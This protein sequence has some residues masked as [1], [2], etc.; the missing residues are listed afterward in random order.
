[1]CVVFKSKLVD[2]LNTDILNMMQKCCH[3][4]H[5]VRINLGFFTVFIKAIC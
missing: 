3:L 4:E 1:M 2:M 5:G